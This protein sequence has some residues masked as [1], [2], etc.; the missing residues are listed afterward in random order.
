M[1]NIKDWKLD[2]YSH[3]GYDI[4]LYGRHHTTWCYIA[5]NCILHSQFCENL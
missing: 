5:H 2:S 3:L 4:M 1:M